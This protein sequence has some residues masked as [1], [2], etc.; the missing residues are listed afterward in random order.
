MGA[1][2]VTVASVSWVAYSHTDRVGELEVEVRDATLDTTGPPTEVSEPTEP[3]DEPGGL[4]T[5]PGGI[6]AASSRKVVDNHLVL[7]GDSVLQAAAPLIPDVLP[8]WSIVADTRVGRF[9]P[10]ATKVLQRRAA[11]LGEVVVLNLGNNY[12]GDP[13][14]FSAE[15]EEAMAELRQVDHVIWI[16]AG[17]FEEEQREVNSVLRAAL[18]RHRNLVLVD[19]N[20]IWDEH[21]RSYTGADDLHLTPKGAE[22]YASMV[23]DAVNRVAHLA[24]IEPAPGPEEPVITTKG[25]VPSSKG[26]GTSGSTARPGRPTTTAPRRDR[27]STTVADEPDGSSGGA[28]DGSNG[29]DGVG[30]DPTV[31]QPPPTSPAPTT[32]GSPTN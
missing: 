30:P 27:T 12:N 17:V 3:L 14:A 13:V 19:W 5:G 10:E 11:D 7:V 24:N 16:N 31:T 6:N 32:P 29:E 8:E 26:S 18:R 2:F 1:T 28:G 20:T 23:A 4:I 9:L 25:S 21:Q 22:A 15:V